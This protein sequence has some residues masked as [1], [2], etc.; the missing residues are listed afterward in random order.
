LH[1]CLRSG[2]LPLARRVHLHL[3]L[4]GLK[5]AL[6]SRTF[7]ANQVL[8]LHFRCRRPA[9][10]WALFDRMHARNAFSYNAM[11]A[12]YAR[13]GMLPPVR[14]VFDGMPEGARDVVSWNTMIIALARAGSGCEAVEMYVRMRRS[15]GGACS[16]FSFSGLLVACV[17]L[18]MPS[19]TRQVHGQVLGMGYLANLIIS[20]SLVD[21]YA[22]CWCIDDARKLFAEMPVKDVLT[23]TTL[24]SGYA[25][26]GD[27][28]SARRLFDEMPEKNHFSWTALIAGYARKGLSHEALDLFAI[29]MKE[30]VGPDQFT[31][32]S[33]L[34]SCTGIS[35]LKHGKQI[36]AHLIRTL[37]NPNAVVLSCLI[38]MY[39]KCGSLLEGQRVFDC[40]TYNKR[41]TVL[42][43]TMI[44]AFGQHGHGKNSIRLFEEMIGIGT[45][46][47]SNTFDAILTAC[48]HSGLYAEGIQI[49]NLMSQDHGVYPNE[50]HYACFVDLL[51]QAGHFEEA[52]GR[53]LKTPIRSSFLVVMHPI[54]SSSI[55]A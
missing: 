15:P 47:D 1:Q 30:G 16:Q 7:L 54:H 17:R 11:L 40:L 50:G 52:L 51:G 5:R 20:S 45:K 10:A 9:D 6:P 39:S 43:N 35:S 24:L 44:S 21:A 53:I 34:C 12:G 25:K 28:V 29:M 55:A 14:R 46:P 49:F 41:D 36:H 2:A 37:F 38:D 32:S 33:A 4:T 31:I 48:S 42:W 26:S 23:W 19:L 22:K 27:F 3:K 18:G 8:A 13:L